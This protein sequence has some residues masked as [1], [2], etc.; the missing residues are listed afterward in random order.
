MSKKLT[1]ADKI[2]EIDER[3]QFVLLKNRSMSFQ[4]HRFLCLGVSAVFFVMSKIDESEIFM[5]IGVGLELA[6]AIS[7]FVDISTFIYYNSRN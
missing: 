1:N 7:L 4:L 6:F 3:N 5:H 2:E